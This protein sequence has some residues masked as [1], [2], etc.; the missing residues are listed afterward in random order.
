MQIYYHYLHCAIILHVT[1]KEH[2]Y[3][4]LYRHYV[5]VLK[6]SCSPNNIILFHIN[7]LFKFMSHITL[8]SEITFLYGQLKERKSYDS[9]TSCLTVINKPSEHHLLQSTTEIIILTFLALTC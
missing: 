3:C 1:D 6:M 5:Y 8:S 7:S 4:M 9:T 2:N